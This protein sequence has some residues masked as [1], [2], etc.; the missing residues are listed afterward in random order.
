MNL[1]TLNISEI[2]QSADLLTIRFIFEGAP[3]DVLSLFSEETA[4]T[5]TYG[6]SIYSGYTEL[7][8]MRYRLAG[9]SYSITLKKDIAKEAISE[10]IEGLDLTDEQ[11][12]GVADYYHA[13]A[14]GTAYR[15]GQ[16]V[17]YNGVLYKV[18]Q[19]HTSQSDW[20][21]LGS[22]SLFAEVLIGDPEGD[23][24]PAWRQPD[25]TNPYNLGD[26]VKHNGI[27]WKSLI[28]GNVWEPN[29][30]NELLGLWLSLD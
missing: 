25:S 1:D 4:Q 9:H 7:I 20:T 23:A 11:A 22:P 10:V 5:I 29:E 15:T 19:A 14:A 12:L 21:P 16:Y 2:V 18:L 3:N 28:N 30:Q 24:V 6:E 26:V 17:R 8:E 27:T 13:W